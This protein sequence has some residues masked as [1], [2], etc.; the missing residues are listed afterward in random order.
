MGSVRLSPQLKEKLDHIA[1]KKGIT[2]SAV[3]RQALEAY[4][5]RESE[6]PLTS[7]YDDIIG[8]ADGPSDLSTRTR[9]YFGETMEEKFSKPSK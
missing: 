5:E 4:C 6:E 7:R 2:R 8:I 3:Y 1:R 9:F